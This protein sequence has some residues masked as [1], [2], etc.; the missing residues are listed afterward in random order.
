[1]RPQLINP[2]AVTT[3]A[4]KTSPE[5]VLSAGRILQGGRLATVIDAFNQPDNMCAVMFEFTPEQ[6]EQLRTN[7]RIVVAAR[8]IGTTSPM[9]VRTVGD[10]DNYVL[11]TIKH[12]PPELVGNIRARAVMAGRTWDTDNSEVY[13]V[14]S[15]H[16]PII[17]VTDVRTS[18]GEYIPK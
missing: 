8:S 9:I 13:E 7:P 5:H 11:I 15:P 2:V 6:I 10:I 1:M 16:K 18:T 3:P 4:T 12:V 14:Y 17:Y